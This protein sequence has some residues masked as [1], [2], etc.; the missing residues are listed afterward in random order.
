MRFCQ[1]AAPEASFGEAPALGAA[2]SGVP[3]GNSPKFLPNL[4]MS[5]T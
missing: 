3:L 2:G 4:M 5:Y 1:L